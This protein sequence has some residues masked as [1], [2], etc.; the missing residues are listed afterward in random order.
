MRKALVLTL[1]LI[2]SLLAAAPAAAEPE[3]DNWIW[4]AT[5]PVTS[6]SIT[7]KIASSNDDDWYMFYASSQM[8]LTITLMPN[9]CGWSLDA[10]LH[11]SSGSVLDSEDF[12]TSV[13][14]TI[15]Y[16]TEVGTHRYF[17]SVE[18]G[19]CGTPY[20][21]TLSP[22]SSLLWGAGMPTATAPTGEPNESAAQAIGPLLGGTIYTG[23][24]Q[25]QNDVDW[26]AFFAS[27]PFTIEAT[28]NGTGCYDLGDSLI[29]RD[30]QQE[31]V[32]GSEL[33]ANRF[34]YLSYTPPAWDLY[35][36]EIDDSTDCAYR[37]SIS[38]ASSIQAG[39]A[40]APTAPAP[41]SGLAYRKTR[42][43]V[44]VYWS[45]TLDATGYQIRIRKG[46][47]W[48][49][50]KTTGNTWKSFKRKKLPK[51]MKVRVRA[52]NAVGAGAAQTI[53]VR[54]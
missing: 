52:I 12:S 14:E 11:D 20:S 37:F 41:M 53:K 26:F 24:M 47:K 28:D 19:A 17:L 42:K 9:P 7:G 25:T 50:W 46:S 6:G 3:P 1:A 31:Y 43:K 29:L 36:I 38:P 35:Y 4:Q 16:T 44:V 49:P 10:A 40:P 45:A 21:I 34:S 39:P 15:K 30:S 54:R 23:A 8:Q 33:D 18:G 2:G 13:Q 48:R 27:G 51:V 5:G 22:A 32:A